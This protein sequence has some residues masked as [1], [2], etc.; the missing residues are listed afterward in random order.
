MCGRFADRLSSTWRSP[1]SKRARVSRSVERHRATYAA[2]PERHDVDQLGSHSEHLDEVIARALRIG[3]HPV[4]AARR[5]GHEHPHALV[6]DARVR[7]GKA[8]VDQVVHGHDPAKTP[9]QRRG[10]RQ[11]VHEIDA[12]SHRQRRQQRLLAEHPLHAVAGVHG[13]GHRRQQLAP[14][15]VFRG[16][17]LAVDERGEAHPSGRL[18]EQRGNQL[19]RGDLHATGLT[20]DEEDQVQTD[21]RTGC[22][23]ANRLSVASPLGDAR[24]RQTII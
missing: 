24:A 12:R 21:V 8:R 18:G 23:Q 15:T 14:R 22:R 11:A 2:E 20:G 4:G 10:A 9:P 7:L 17:S 13:H 1:S 6:A 3:D 19:A 16:G 5:L